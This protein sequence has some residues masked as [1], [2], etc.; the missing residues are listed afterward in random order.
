MMGRSKFIEF[1]SQ[2]LANFLSL[3][4]KFFKYI[5]IVSNASQKFWY[6]FGLIVKGLAY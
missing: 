4:K 3:E 5:F 2:A 1:S 6:I